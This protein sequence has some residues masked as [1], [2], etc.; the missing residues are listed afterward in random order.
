MRA[1]AVALLL[2]AV[3]CKKSEDT[4]TSGPKTTAPTIKAATVVATEAATPDVLVLTGTIIAD[5]RAEVTADT[6][7]KVIN[8]LIQRGDHVKLG[9]PVIQLDV[10][11]AQMSAREAQ[12]ALQSA[13]V[14]K[15]LA[16]E[17]CART[18]AL[19]DKGAITKSEFDRQNTQCL[20][21][22]EQV[23]QAQARTDMMSKSVADGMVRAPF[24]GVV[25]EKNVSPGEWVAPG[26]PLF[27]LVDNDPLK[28]E[29]SVPEKAVSWVKKDQ[30]VDVIAVAHPEK[31]YSASI[32]RLGAEIGRS[33]ALVV[34]ATL[35]KTDDL[36]PG[37]FAEA[38]ITVDH[39]SRVV[40]PETAVKSIGKTYHAFVVGKDNIVEDRLVQKGE[41]S[42]PGK[43]TIV[44]GVA[45]GE[46]VVAAVPDNMVDGAK[47]TE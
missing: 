23:A 26:K 44:Q 33:R 10:R 9:Q 41:S 24:E 6:Q 25:S 30:H 28:I 15:Q 20:N 17:E 1:L 7:G 47:V 27:T 31:K 35:D 46:K 40:L 45:K 5:Q 34:E 13:R 12:A 36:V 39:S 21:A 3:G 22:I 18:K 14:S 32:T 43:V 19:L 4:V 37:M 29:L 16:D 8:V 11:S 2:V 42:E 38:H